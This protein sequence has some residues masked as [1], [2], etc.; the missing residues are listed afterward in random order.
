MA[1]HFAWV[2]KT[3][4]SWSSTFARDDEN[5]F[6]YVLEH[7]EGEFATLTVEIKNPRVGLLAGSRKRWCWL[8]RD[9]LGTA[10][11][12]FFGRVIGFPDDMVQEVITLQFVAK[13]V[14]YSTRRA[15]M[16]E[17]LKVAP[18]WDPVF[19]DEEQLQDP[20]IVLNSRP[21]LWHIDPVTHVV[22]ISDVCVG[23]DGIIEIDIDEGMRDSVNMTFTTPP[24]KRVNIF[25]QGA[26]DQMGVGSIE[27]GNYI[28][29]GWNGPP[30][31]G[32]VNSRA[33]VT[34]NSDLITKWPESGKNVGGGWSVGV[35][36]LEP[37]RF[38]KYGRVVFNDSGIVKSTIENV[39]NPGV[40]SLPIA[41]ADLN[42]YLEPVAKTGRT[43]TPDLIYMDGYTYF[44]D[45]LPRDVTKP[46]PFRYAMNVYHPNPEGDFANNPGMSDGSL[47]TQAVIND[48]QLPVYVFRARLQMV[49]DVTRRRKE[50]LNTYLE[51]DCQ[52]IVTEDDDDSYVDLDFDLVSLNLPVDGPDLY[53]VRDI[54]Q[55]GYFNTA[56]GQQSIEYML[57][58]AR[59]VL[60]SRARCA[61]VAVDITVSKA[62]LDGVSLRKNAKLTDA[63]IPGGEAVGKISRYRMS[64]N[65]DTGQEICS[66]L[67][68]CMVGKG[69][70]IIPADGDPT[71]VEEGYV[72]KGYQR[73]EG[74]TVGP[75]SGD[76]TYEDLTGTAPS[77]DDGISFDDMK[78]SQCVDLLS[79]GPSWADQWQAMIDGYNYA[80]NRSDFVWQDGGFSGSSAGTPLSPGDM[81]QYYNEACPFEVHVIMKDLTGEFESDYTVNTSKLMVPHGIDLE[82]E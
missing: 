16:A 11:P 58:C 18:Y 3:D 54:R 49:F 81:F 4:S 7:T 59:A 78:L 22:T 5:V 25:A 61:N 43:V 8:S 64:L 24:A 20:N 28:N 68:G 55:N 62:L 1:Y 21:A 70:S 66:V 74:L 38:Y 41:P 10:V 23:E 67:F 57:M 53:P 32:V 51:A 33:I 26:W 30:I 56:R 40:G 39:G 27:L 69:N 19:F 12:M 63:R 77:N 60:L 15:A 6:S 50:N 42:T 13:P 37:V 80:I 47:G 34:Y 79:T 36:Y 31:P 73:Y 45:P 35:S 44:D 75:I 76:L 71:Y 48:L 14:D 52:E 17:T 29:N 72:E 2:D 82:A 9:V 65:G 46:G